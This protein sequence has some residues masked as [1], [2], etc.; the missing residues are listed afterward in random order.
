M[1][2]YRAVTDNEEFNDGGEW[3]TQFLQLTA[4]HLES[5]E[6]FV[7]AAANIVTIVA[8][9]RVAPPSFNWS[10][11]TTTTYVITDR[12]ISIHVKGNPRGPRLPH[13][14]A[15]IGLNLTLPGVYTKCEWFGRGPGESY[16]DSKRSQRFG[17]WS[18]L[19]SDLF[20]H[21]E[22]P[23]ESSNR[24]DV[25][26]VTFSENDGEGPL[27]ANF[28]DQKGCSFMASHYTTEDIDSSKHPHELEK[29]KKKE[30]FVRLDWAHQGLGT[31]SCGPK[32][33]PKY[34]LRSEPFEFE[35]LLE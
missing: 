31:G 20:T 6:T 25:R 2:F 14:F 33:L 24:T 3:K 19:I 27:R 12:T 13:T 23:Q 30:V 18:M 4:S 7:D 8:Q 1:D 9:H 22:F 34:E 5:F 17:N 11:D 26:W 32:V 15:R 16:C 28:G 21:Y 35:L 10:V 29:K